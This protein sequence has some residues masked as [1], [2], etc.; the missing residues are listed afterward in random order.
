MR[1]WNTHRQNLHK[2]HDDHTRTHAQNQAYVMHTDINWQEIGVDK[3]VELLYD[4][5]GHATQTEAPATSND[6]HLQ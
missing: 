2:H 4:P 6:S 5:K 1:V 3:P